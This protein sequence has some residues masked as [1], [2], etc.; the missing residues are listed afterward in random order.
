[1]K[2]ISLFSFV[3]ALLVSVQFSF[4][5]FC[6]GQSGNTVTLSQVAENESC[7]GGMSQAPIWSPDDE[8]PEGA[9]GCNNVVQL[10]VSTVVSSAATVFELG[11]DIDLGGRA[12]NGACNMVFSPI[13]FGALGGRSSI[14]TVNGNNHK[15]AGLCYAERLTEN[16]GYY[17]W[18]PTPYSVPSGS[19]RSF[20]TSDSHINMGFFAELSDVSVSNLKFENAY[21]AGSIKNQDQNFRTQVGVVVGYSESSTFT[22][23][24][25]ENSVVSGAFAGA[26]VGASVNDYFKDDTVS[27]DTVRFTENDSLCLWE[28]PVGSGDDEPIVRGSLGG[29]A[30]TMD[31]SGVS[32]FTVG[33]I[34]SQNNLIEN[35][36]FKF[37]NPEGEP[38]EYL[39]SD[40]SLGGVAGS[41]MTGPATS[42]DGIVAKGNKVVNGYRMGSV[43]GLVAGGK[44]S[45]EGCVVS[46]QLA[47]KNISVGDL[48][49]F[50][51]ILIET[52]GGEDCPVLGSTIGGFVG[53]VG[54][55][56]SAFTLEKS[57]IYENISVPDCGSK[58]VKVGG[59][60]GSVYIAS[61]TINSNYGYGNVSIAGSG[62]NVSGYLAA[63]IAN[64]GDVL[65]AA[66]YFYD[67]D[68]KTVDEL[69]GRPTSEVGSIVGAEF[70]DEDVFLFNFF[71]VTASG[72]QGSFDLSK[73][74]VSDGAGTFS[75]NG[76][77]SGDFMKSKMFAAYLNYAS[78]SLGFSSPWVFKSGVNENLPAFA[79]DGGRG[80]IL[81]TVDFTMV[82]E[83]YN[84]V[85]Y[86]GVAFRNNYCVSKDGRMGFAVFASDENGVV[87]NTALDSIVGLKSELDV[88]NIY[89]DRAA[90]NNQEPYGGFVDRSLFGSEVGGAVSLTGYQRYTAYV[91]RDYGVEFEYRLYK[92]R[93]D[94][95]YSIDFLGGF[96]NAKMVTAPKL[97]FPW[98]VKSSYESFDAED[99]LY[100]E[101]YAYNATENP[102]YRRLV[103]HSR[104][105]KNGSGDVVCNEPVGYKGDINTNVVQSDIPKDVFDK[106]L[107]SQETSGTVVLRYV[108]HASYDGSSYTDALRKD[109]LQMYNETKSGEIPVRV[110]VTPVFDDANGKPSVMPKGFEPSLLDRSKYPDLISVGRVSPKDVFATARYVVSAMPGYVMNSYF[111]SY[112]LIYGNPSGT[113]NINLSPVS[114]YENADAL[115]VALKNI[116]R[117]PGNGKVIEIPLVEESSADTVYI[118]SLYKALVKAGAWNNADYTQYVFVTP[119]GRK[120]NYY[121]DYDL[122]LDELQSKI[123]SNGYP[124]H[125]YQNDDDEMGKNE[126]A[127][128]LVYGHDADM[129]IHVDEGLPYVYGLY[130]ADST[131][132]A[133]DVAKVFHFVS[134]EVPTE[135]NGG[136]WIWN[137]KSVNSVTAEIISELGLEENEALPAAVEWNR[138]NDAS[139]PTVHLRLIPE[140]AFAES[141]D[142]MCAISSYDGSNVNP[143]YANNY[144]G[145]VQLT[146][147][148]KTTGDTLSVNYLE[149]RVDKVSPYY[150]SDSRS[151][152]MPLPR[153]NDTLTFDIELKP[154]YGF[155][156]ELIE[157]APDMSGEKGNFFYNNTAYSRKAFVSAINDGTPNASCDEGTQ[158]PDSEW[159]LLRD[160]VDKD[161]N[162]RDVLRL[163]PLCMGDSIYLV[164]RY[165]PKNF[166]FKFAP[167]QKALSLTKTND[168]FIAYD[169]DLGSERGETPWEKQFVV[170]ADDTERNFPKVYSSRGCATWTPQGNLNSESDLP[171]GDFV[172]VHDL[173]E[174]IDSAKSKGWDY[175]FLKDYTG[176]EDDVNTLYPVFNDRDCFPID[177][178]MHVYLDNGAG[179][180]TIKLVQYLGSID[181]TDDAF[182]E[183]IEHSFEDISGGENSQYPYVLNVPQVEIPFVFVVEATPEDGY[184]LDK[185][186]Y[187]EPVMNGVRTTVMFEGDTVIVDDNKVLH[188]KFRLD[189]PYYVKYDLGLAEDDSGKVFIPETAVAEQTFAR[190]DFNGN[191]W[192]PYHTD[193]CFMGWR[194]IDKDGNEGVFTSVTYEDLANLSLDPNYPTGLVAEWRERGAGCVE[195]QYT[196]TL[197][198]LT[199][200][201]NSWL[202]AYQVL[203][204]DTLWHDTISFD[205]VRIELGVEK[206]NI[207]L[208]PRS[209][210]GY[211]TT[212]PVVKESS[213]IVSAETDGSYKLGHEEAEFTYGVT[214][215]SSQNKYNFAFVDNTDK[216]VIR[217]ESDW[218]SFRSFAYGEED[219]L[220]SLI[221]MDGAC[222]V[223]WSISPYGV[224][225]YTGNLSDNEALI[226]ELKNAMIETRD[227]V[228][229]SKLYAIWDEN[230]I[231][232]CPELENMVSVQTGYPEN[233]GTFELIQRVDGEETK[234]FTVTGDAALDIPQATNA[235]VKF[236]PG[237]DF[238][239]YF[240][241]DSDVF[242][243]DSVQVVSEYYRTSVGANT[244]VNFN[245]YSLGDVEIRVPYVVSKK[246]YEFV[247]DANG[248]NVLYAPIWKTNGKS[249][250]YAVISNAQYEDFGYSTLDAGFLLKAGYCHNLRWSFEKTV[251]ANTPVYKYVTPQFVL[252]LEFRKASNLQVDTLYAVWSEGDCPTYG[253]ESPVVIS[254]PDSLKG[255]MTIEFLQNVDGVDSVVASLGYQ[256]L[257]I[258]QLGRVEYDSAVVFTGVRLKANPGYALG[259]SGSKIYYST[260]SNANL[261]PLSTGGFLE[262]SENTVLTAAASVLEFA[263]AF[264][265]N[266]TSVF[267]QG[268][269]TDQKTFKMSDVEANRMFPEVVS[270]VGCFAG[271]SWDKDAAYGEGF[272][273]FND[274]FAAGFVNAASVDSVN[275]VPVLYAVWQSEEDGCVLNSMT[276]A[277]S[278]PGKGSFTL[279]Q[280][281]NVYLVPD[282]GA[283]VPVDGGFAFTLG[284]VPKAGLYEYDEIAGVSVVNTDDGSPVALNDG[285]LEV[286]ATNVTLKATVSPVATMFR[287]DVN[288]Q[289]TVYFGSSWKFKAE[290]DADMSLVQSAFP[291]SAYR[292]DACLVGWS[293][294]KD[295]LVAEAMVAFDAALVKTL[296]T[297]VA[298]SVDGVPVLYAVWNTENCNQTIFNV[299]SAS[300]S[301]GDLYL[302]TTV[303]GE[304]FAYP[305]GEG[306]LKVPYKSDLK[307]VAEFK[308]YNGIALD[309]DSYFYEVNARGDKLKA[310]VN[311]E[312]QVVSDAIVKAP[313]KA[314]TYVVYFDQNAYDVF[315]GNGWKSLT[316][317]DV[318]MNYGDREL[319]MNIYR[320]GYKLAGWELQDGGRVYRVFNDTL[321]DEFR[322]ELFA[323]DADT[324]SLLAVWAAD[325]TSP[326]VVTNITPTSGTLSLLQFVGGDT[327]RFA[328]SD[329]GLKVPAVDGGLNFTA[330]FTP[331]TG[332]IT[333]GLNP[334]F[335]RDAFNGDVELEN[336]RITVK[337]SVSV[338]AVVV[339][340]GYEFA[341]NTNAGS[342][343]VFF[344]SDWVSSGSFSASANPMF[345]SELYRT[346]A[347]FKGWSLAATSSKGYK[348]FDSE[349]A[350]ALNQI[351]SLGLP[352]NTLYAVWDGYCSDNYTVVSK[353]G[354]NGVFELVQT[355][356]GIDLPAVKVD[357]KGALIPVSTSGLAFNVKFVEN[358]G[359][360]LMEGESLFMEVGEAVVDSAENGTSMVIAANTALRATVSADKFRLTYDVNGGDSYVYFGD[361]WKRTAE[362][363]LDDDVV[364]LPKGI[365][366]ADATLVGW[367]SKKDADVS[368]AFDK[369]TLGLVAEFEEGKVENTLYAIWD[370]TA[371]VETFMVTFA[372]AEI[373][374]L[375]LS[376]VADD[377][378]MKYEVPQA[379]LP[380]PIVEGGLKFKASYML[381][382][383]Y[384]AIDADSLYVV[385]KNGLVGP[386]LVNGDLLVDK[387]V[388]LTVPTEA[389]IYGIVFNTNTSAEPVFY[390]SDWMDSSKFVLGDENTVLDLPMLVY[391]T[392]TCVVGWALKSA[393]EN[394]EP[395]FTQ[396]NSDLAA[397]FKE[398]GERS[399]KG[400][401]KMYA[402]WGD[403]EQCEAY[404]RIQLASENGS[405]LLEEITGAADAEPVVHPFAEDGS[406]LLPK[407]VNGLQF[408]VRSVPDSSYMLDSL[409]V[410]RIGDDEFRHVTFENGSLPRTLY[411]TEFKAYFGKANHTPL[412][413]V[414]ADF[415]QS[416]NAVRFSFTTSDF[417][418]TRGASL[419]AVVID[420]AGTVVVDTVFAD[421]I[422]SSFE[423]SWD[424]FPVAVGSYSVEFSIFDDR[425][426]FAFDTSFTVVS[427][428]AAVVA[429]GWQMISLAA[430]DTSALVWDDDAQFY[431]WD[432]STVAAEFWQYRAF[433]RGDEIVKDRGFWYSSLQGRTVPLR[434][435]YEDD[436]SDV[437]WKLDSLNSGWNLVANPHGWA[438]DLF[439]DKPAD[440]AD[441]N[442]E[443]PISFW[444]YDA[445]SADYKEVETIGPYEAV[446]VKVSGPTEWTVPSKPIFKADAVVLTD[447]VGTDS[448]G[449]DTL[450][451]SALEK[452][453]ALAKAASADSWS[454][455]MVLK[456]GAGRT[457][458][459]NMLGVSNKPFTAEEPPAS[460]GNHVS[461][462]I[463]DGNRALAKSVKAPASE[464]EWKV[465]L[466]A[467]SNRRGFLSF[468]G[469]SEIRQY[470]YKVFVTID[471][472]TSEVGENE[473]LD[474]SLTTRAKYA[475][476][477]VAPTANTVVVG[478]VRNLRAAKVGRELNVSFIADKA[479][480]G[481]KTRVD[482]MD[483]KGH[484]IATVNAKAVAGTNK[485][486][487]EAP[488]TGL[489][490]LR[491]RA[492]SQMSAGKVVVK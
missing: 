361:G 41:L 89:M 353:N 118:D 113:D 279:S 291:M 6:V 418:V 335:T 92:T 346:D 74:A 151:F 44:D 29:F 171:V 354:Q 280:N 228:D 413:F 46:S 141:I 450:G 193:K 360:T 202:S 305:V 104:C 132:S 275:G 116:L 47:M 150:S 39:S 225:G 453:R 90:R 85:D 134:N 143:D 79:E 289:D 149:E 191:L 194:M 158:G 398:S 317:F 473:E 102:E 112:Y 174:L 273:M 288:T 34:V 139:R 224:V 146:Q 176:D 218:E 233:F 175:T 383:G 188:A 178:F 404:N 435:D 120:L 52:K 332:Y 11:S 440:K 23:V 235:Y 109:S 222:F 101:V 285:V 492:G 407:I 476:V 259:E 22:N 468:K 409:V 366:R 232:P 145:A 480:A 142:D 152:F 491:V 385:D 379:G 414:K 106:W 8:C 160:V 463:M 488:K 111:V 296:E 419:S 115:A 342:A 256:D 83:V 475:T 306:A 186:W 154:D 72:S 93:T 447:S 126:S 326:Y 121:L 389:E 54:S 131:V 38:G 351:Q 153:T 213:N 205:G 299:T 177:V 378:I 451:G 456:D 137:D 107:S 20:G 470:G 37:E 61:L 483:M 329:A 432:E 189:G 467:T 144:H 215:N 216:P 88:K 322:N 234:I 238:D 156:M 45:P 170:S 423:S 434:T 348:K 347:C 443:A 274:A 66:N 239:S 272:E 484:V 454:L 250:E 67:P 159:G 427:E 441:G 247:F 334:L 62:N 68:E 128:M 35:E 399:S 140:C 403:A 343:H 458:A 260:E 7:A 64:Y 430:I 327:A 356:E 130:K 455:Q 297:A 185:V 147:R 13:Y 417:E 293:L 489:Y 227:G 482:L 96:S 270:G 71:N 324:V 184:R 51:T 426:S 220:G 257:L 31:Y 60:L 138:E 254:L 377:E 452:S 472:K 384:S 330:S 416:G 411:N 438:M 300:L 14:T 164:P 266:G 340:D 99:S 474:V 278:E 303:D 339:P 136:A 367:S 369:L 277:S 240:E 355:V 368:E 312:M 481:A 394:G 408:F 319:P 195:P 80:N 422:P 449:T 28:N 165:M 122:K 73:G 157:F 284:F 276:I 349:F 320:V 210:T 323:S 201:E 387:D 401:F 461:L 86:P 84:T 406:I 460:L 5:D 478:E 393:V 444:K 180:G 262:F 166:A 135:M 485:L 163:N 373:G 87:S 196:F 70:D 321:I 412:E 212:E 448:L 390:G 381:I 263:F 219:D 344:G 97:L 124:K 148:D 290:Y 359:Y 371:N 231:A 155:D 25:V 397:A 50:E 75:Q 33:G 336:S 255:R 282:E 264:N 123:E 261:A 445:L 190:E 281:G 396:F 179:H 1:M 236:V 392:T 119:D 63:T 26:F 114:E 244:T 437:V 315:Y 18:M 110:V 21:V 200:D 95:P 172:G 182:A 395:V 400:Y 65:V 310:L 350:A 133:N 302:T 10:V 328:V 211:S 424:L 333:S 207:F 325:T 258:P 308:P 318:L 287:F 490:M 431:W 30:G 267:R 16:D 59:M 286:S 198:A 129:Q 183:R 4:A 245:S 173:D 242:G 40:V 217:S 304:K 466:S 94:S 462:S 204:S 221:R 203:G 42:L 251:D 125:I 56:N 36:I 428:V 98:R 365:Y 58:S 439:G 78:D 49:T 117:N 292:I 237:T 230:P 53:S 341:L 48:E 442:E 253:S 410:T 103:Y 362:M 358:P 309:D 357:S 91:V 459:W 199:Q 229:Y 24:V 405:I 192:S 375:T 345:P 55:C 76:Y 402:V 248:E 331:K 43:A 465:A 301:E 486:A 169:S 246:S 12:E 425:E 464:N 105:F 420:S 298:D 108:D 436:N 457:D 265:D 380:V 77:I 252:D 338:G 15:V 243:T 307:F 241:F 433:E 388:E 429:D 477:R 208:L 162:K 370:T 226:A 487:F 295:A 421:S 479:L 3:L 161:G 2:K 363:T 249:G 223:G 82:P 197:K 376:Q 415:V 374:S 69:S 209:K 57:S 17:V 382:G 81:F 268:D 167:L 206:Y 372:E 9:T 391:S 283:K 311:G 168:A 32:N 294:K 214:W 469:V 386:S 446:W 100:N 269:W 19:G 181:T 27:N 314:K 187:E 313:V 271:W 352:S 471:G 127:Y 316:E 364:V 337:S